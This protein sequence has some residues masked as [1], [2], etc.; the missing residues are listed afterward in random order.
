MSEEKN[1]DENLAELDIIEL[2]GIDIVEFHPLPDGKGNPTQ[3]HLITRPKGAPENFRLVMRFKSRQIITE[4][5]DALVKHRNHV[6]P[7]N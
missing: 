2:E 4:V 7:R 1:Y 3:V 6:W 5:I